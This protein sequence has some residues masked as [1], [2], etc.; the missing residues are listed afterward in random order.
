MVQCAGHHKERHSIIGDEIRH[1][2]HGLGHIGTS[3]VRRHGKYCIFNTTKTFWMTLI[4]I[5]SGSPP[6]CTEQIKGSREE[7]QEDGLEGF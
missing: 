2:T 1:I 5:L 4:V 3:N 6:T 7:R